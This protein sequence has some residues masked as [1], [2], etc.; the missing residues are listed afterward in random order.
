MTDYVYDRSGR[1]VG[2]IRGR[3][4]HAMNGA[5]IGQ[6]SGTRVHKM[7][8]SYVGELHDQMVV[9]KNLGNFGNIGNPGN[10]GNAGNP[11]NP[12]N[13]GARGSGYRDVFSDLLGQQPLVSVPARFLCKIKSADTRQFDLF[14]SAPFSPIEPFSSRA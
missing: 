5:A 3:Y 11:G 7:S 6:M 2:Y 10:P 4:I 13:R 8:G 14:A 12:G 1:A 9:D